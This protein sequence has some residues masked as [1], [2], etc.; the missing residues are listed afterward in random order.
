MQLSR[1][2]RYLCQDD[3]PRLGKPGRMEPGYSDFRAWCRAIIPWRFRQPVS[4]RGS[5][6]GSSTVRGPY[7]HLPPVVLQIAPM[8]PCP[9]WGS[10]EPRSLI[11]D[12][13]DQNA[14]SIIG[15]VVRSPGGLPTMPD[16]KVVLI[17]RDH[18]TVMDDTRTDQNG[19]SEFRD[20]SPGWYKITESLAGYADFVVSDIE[21]RTGQTT[22]IAPWLE[23]A[24][25]P[26]GL[27]CTPSYNVHL[28]AICL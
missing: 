7:T 14:S 13:R 16:V 22:K 11:F 10:V 19:N 5:S 24:Q 12:R 3:A 23:I 20:V 21:V 6:R 28:P 1:V 2:L 4:P 15:L 18:H 27:H 25:C 8:T 9:A 26:R 17:D